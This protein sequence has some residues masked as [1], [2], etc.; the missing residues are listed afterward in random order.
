MTGL[1]FG[2]ELASGRFPHFAYLT[3]SGRSSLRLILGSGFAGKTFLLPDFLCGIIPE[4]LAEL[5]ARF[6]FYH[7]GESFEIDE[8]SVRSQSFDVLYVIDYFGYRSE[9]GHLAGKDQWVIEDCVFLPEV[10]QQCACPNWIGY[11]SLRKTTALADG[12]VVLS[13]VPLDRSLIADA[14]APFAGVKYAAKL[15]K[16]EFLAGGIG[17]EQDYLDLFNQAEKMIDTQQRVHSMSA[18]SLARYF[19]LLANLEKEMSRRRENMDIL[20]E[21]LA[22]FDAGVVSDQPSHFVMAL[23]RRNALRKRLRAQRIFLPSHWP[24]THGPH[25][26]LYDRVLAISVNARYSAAEI[27]R[28]ADLVRNSLQ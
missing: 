10:S 3:D 25:N 21:R 2:G 12:S 8:I 24:H 15:N 18:E 13:T 9:F 7:I 22:Q 14:E 20:R 11:N 26:P 5:G 19:A 4:V 16:H 28:V 6:S 17:E 23:E 1:P 27:S